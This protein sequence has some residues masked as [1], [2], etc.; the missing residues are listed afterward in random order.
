MYVKSVFP[1]IEKINEIPLIGGFILIIFSA[2]PGAFLT[3]FSEYVYNIN[4]SQFMLIAFSSYVVWNFLL[5]K[6]GI[7]IYLFF[8]PAWIFWIGV[9]VLV[10]VFKL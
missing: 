6:I 3:L 1:S 9:S 10:L 2:L 5:M 4:K 8:I 7:K